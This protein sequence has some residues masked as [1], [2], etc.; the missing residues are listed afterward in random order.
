MQEIINFYCVFHN[1]LYNYL[2]EIIF[3]G[4][5]VRNSMNKKIVIALGGNALGGTL[6]EQ[7]G[8]VKYTSKTIADL[9]ESGYDVVIAHGNGP[10]VGM[11]N[12]AFAEYGKVDVKF[13][14]MPLPN[15]VAMSQAYIGRI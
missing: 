13:P 1:A 14:F 9:V 4:M 15:C 12:D 11:I 3:T 2:N 5:K 6:E 10:Q 8:A 7:M